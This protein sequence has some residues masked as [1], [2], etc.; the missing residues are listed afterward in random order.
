MSRAAFNHDTDAFTGVSFW[1]YCGEL[2]EDPG[3][4]MCP[5][6]EEVR[7]FLLQHGAQVDALVRNPTGGHRSL[8]TTPD[9]VRAMFQFL[10]AVP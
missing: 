3:W 2:D 8:P 7:I 9:A 5:A 1:L 6:M 10:E 4:A